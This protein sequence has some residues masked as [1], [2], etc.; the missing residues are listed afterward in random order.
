MIRRPPRSTLFP[1]T[2]LFRS[3]FDAYGFAESDTVAPGD[4]PVVIEIG[5]AQV[6]LSTC[7]DL[8]FPGLYTTLADAGAELTVVAASWGA[9]PGKVEQWELLARARALDATTFVAACGQADPATVGVKI[10]R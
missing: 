6:G 1:Y 3:L 7:Y 9:G 2:T 5:G 10:G 4:K 8:R